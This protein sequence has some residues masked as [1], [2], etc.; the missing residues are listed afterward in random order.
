MPL[1]ADLARRRD[2]SPSPSASG[3]VAGG[4]RAGGRRAWPS[5]TWPNAVRL[6]VADRGLDARRFDLV[7]FGG[8][9]PL[10]AAALAQAAGLSGVVVPPHPGLAS[11]FGAIAADLRVDRRLTRRCA[12][13]R[14]H[15]AALARR[16]AARRRRGAGGAAARGPA[17]R[18]DRRAAS[19]SCRYLGQNFEQRRRRAAGRAATAWTW[20]RASASTRRTRPPTATGCP[21]PWSSSCTSAPSPPTTAR[22][23]PTR[24]RRPAEPGEPHAVRPVCFDGRG[25]DTPIYRRAVLAAGQRVAGPA[26]IEEVDSTTLVPPGWHRRGPRAAAAWC[27]HA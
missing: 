3:I 27:S 24:R 14:G 9:G 21:T 15:G 10:H 17:G 20:C 25:L 13:T 6:V 2:A 8:A 23:R 5:R 26:V 16:P 18:A 4:R 11:A 1:D 7:A 19:V 22:C 12:R